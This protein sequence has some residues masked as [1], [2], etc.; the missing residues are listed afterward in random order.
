[1]KWYFVL[2]IIIIS[3]LVGYLLYW[4][5]TRG[6]NGNG[7]NGKDE[8]GKDENGKFKVVEAQPGPEDG[9]APSGPAAGG[10]EGGPTAAVLAVQ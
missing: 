5:S 7:K 2:G 3:M 8:N 10:P 1:M 6:K 9:G 4:W